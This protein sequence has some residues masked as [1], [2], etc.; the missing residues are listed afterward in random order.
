MTYADGVSVVISDDAIGNIAVDGK[1]TEVNWNGSGF[2]MV[3]L[4]EMTL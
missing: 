1:E 4:Q 2:T 3:P